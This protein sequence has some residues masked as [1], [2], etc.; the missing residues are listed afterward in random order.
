[1]ARLKK[2][3]PDE[4]MRWAKTGAT[5]D[6]IAL[7]LKISPATL[8]RRLTKTK[9]REAYEGG[10]GEMLTSLRAKQ[11]QVALSGN[12]VMLK[13]LG[14][15]YLGQAT[16]H[17]FVDEKG[18]DKPIVDVSPTNMLADRIAGIIERKRAIGSAP[19]I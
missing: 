13:W 1:M 16:A 3:D 8:D 11:V 18:K 4:I 17:R 19:G 14:E 12:V 6:E 5:L 9:F 10:R 15:Q 2:V 7:R